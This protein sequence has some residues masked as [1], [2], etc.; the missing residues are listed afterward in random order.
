MIYND[1]F[2][3]NSNFTVTHLPKDYVKGGYI[4]RRNRAHYLIPF[5]LLSMFIIHIFLYY[6]LATYKHSFDKSYGIFLNST[7][8]EENRFF[9]CQMIIIDPQFYN[10]IELQSLKAQGHTIYA[11]LNIGSIEHF[12]DYYSD[13]SDMS[14][15]SYAK[16]NDAQWVDITNP[17]WRHKICNLAKR[18]SKYDIDGFF[19]DN[20]N[21][22]SQYNAEPVYN[23]ILNILTT[24]HEL[25]EPVIIGGGDKFVSRYIDLNPNQNAPVFDA[26]Y[27]ESLFTYVNYSKHLFAVTSSSTRAYYEKYLR[28]C[29]DFGL[30][31]YMYEHTTSPETKDEIQRFANENNYKYC[32]SESFEAN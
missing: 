27:Q 20:V 21:I 25:G 22:Y 14:L 8:G 29:K 9:D 1:D 10:E 13:F 30:D 18:M 28:K 4:S 6:Y 31:V 12:R 16:H 2:Q 3:R 5:F 17:K 7:H 19:I 11:Y 15:G 32:I 24:I 26:V 23:S